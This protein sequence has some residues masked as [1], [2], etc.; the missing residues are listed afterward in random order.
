VRSR[1][2]NQAAG[3]PHWAQNFAPGG[4]VALHLPQVNG[5]SDV[6]H[7]LQKSAPGVFDA[8]H[9]GHAAPTSGGIDAG[10]R[11]QPFPSPCP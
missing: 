2:G 1:W 11:P 7:R 8:R 6:P 4:I 9:C 10:A 3:L 5:A